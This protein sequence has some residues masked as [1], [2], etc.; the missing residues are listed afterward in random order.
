MMYFSSRF[1]R[2]LLDKLESAYGRYQSYQLD[3]IKGIE[4]VKAM[5]GE[6][7]FRQLM[8]GQFTAVSRRR[9]T[10]V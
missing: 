6:S 10:A 1:L 8:L 9:F 4:T 7:S 5:G 3:A 2:P